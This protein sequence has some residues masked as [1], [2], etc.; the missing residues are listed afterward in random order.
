MGELHM[1][2]WTRSLLGLVC[3]GVMAVASL[4]SGTAS[5]AECSNGNFDSTFALIQKAVFEN[6]GCTNDLCHGSAATGGLDL[7]ADVAYENLIDVEAQTVPGQIRVRPGRRD[8]SLLFL[9]LA[10]KTLP[11]QYTAPIRAM[12][13]DPVPALTS[14]ELEAVRKWI[15]AGAQKDGVVKGTAEL[16]D[17]CL[18]PPKPLEIKPLEPP[19]PGTGVQIRMPKWILVP[20]SEREVCFTSY[21]D[22]TDQVPAQFRSPDGK[23]FRYKR[24]EIRQ[25]P[26]SHHLIVSL[27]HGDAPPDDPSWGTYKCVG[28]A[29]EGQPCSAT[30]T[31]FC[32]EGLCATDPVTSIAC[33]GFGPQDIER[34]LA[35][36]GFTGTQETASEFHYPEGVYN[37]L[38]LR[39]LIVWN[40]HAFN[41]TDTAGKLEAWLNFTFAA[42]EEQIT[43]A[44]GIFDA[45]EIFQTNV[46]PFKT[47]EICAL[48][49]LAPNAHLYELSSHAHQR[50]KRWRTFEGAFTCQGGPANGQACSPLGYD[51]VSPDVCKGAPCKSLIRQHVCD[52]NV[53]SEVTIDEIVASVSIALGSSAVSTCTDADSNGD[54]EVTVDELL[55]GVNAALSGV[56]AP[57]ERDAAE[58]LLYVSYIYNDPLVLRFDPPMVMTSPM[59][60][61][62]SLT[63]CALYDNGYTNPDQVKK[64]STSPNPPINVPGVGGPCSKPT[65]CTVGKV[66]A[67]C[68]GGNPT[69][70][71]QSCDTTTGA[72]DGFCDACTLT[73]GVTTEDEMFLLL[74][75]FYV[76]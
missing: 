21:Y 16:L 38:P 72:G 37:E 35:N 58:S 50:M 60:A 1:R 3:L 74:G 55:K 28:G 40:S 48:H 45:H 54:Q 4:C 44:Q 26:I 52:C 62:R 30:D 61:E 66:G 49:E 73:G 39:G 70:R 57:T 10:A 36:S 14:D 23:N 51:F 76:P 71:N 7:R 34:G 19:P 29:L 31:T 18:P 67:T 25:D 5:A 24:N 13:L 17:A 32:G 56:P 43:P 8:E 69:K 41:L 68:T 42:P 65:G 46:A 75:G 12:P 6:R 63:Y 11:S 27:Y 20:Q 15:E 2:S 9:N 64:Q 33:I 22:I 53:D 47:Q 59:P